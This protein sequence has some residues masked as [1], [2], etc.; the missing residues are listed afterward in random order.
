MSM[1]IQRSRGSLGRF[2]KTQTMKSGWGK[3]TGKPADSRRC[4]AKSVICISRALA[5]LTDSGVHADSLLHQ[6][7]Q[8]RCGSVAKTASATGKQGRNLRH[9]LCQMWV[10]PSHSIMYWRS[11]RIKSQRDLE[12]D[13]RRGRAVAAERRQDGD[14]VHGFLSAT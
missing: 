10:I 4:S 2:S 5:S 3:A 14:D 11:L 8:G 9:T 6:K 12:H 7:S 13:Q 1:T